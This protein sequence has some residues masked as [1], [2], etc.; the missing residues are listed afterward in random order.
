[1]KRCF[2]K[3]ISL[4]AL[5]VMFLLPVKLLAQ[6][7]E[8]IIPATHSAHTVVM[9]PD[10]KWLVSAG[11]EGMKIWDNKTGSLLKNLAPGGKDLSRFYGGYI[12]MAFDNASRSL[13]MQVEDTI[14]IFD[15]E[16]FAI[17]NRIKV[18]GKRTAMVFSKMVRDCLLLVSM[19]M[20]M[21]LM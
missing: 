1:M 3:I 14:Y 18:D 13:A 4:T 21:I 16:R 17:S 7:P 11:G 2:Y 5:L 20:I 19:E 15:F 9:S 6:R 10:E 8:L 12:I